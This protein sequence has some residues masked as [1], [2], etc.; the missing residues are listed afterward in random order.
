M[1]EQRLFWEKHRDESKE[2]HPIYTY[3]VGMT[4]SSHSDNGMIWKT[5]L[6]DL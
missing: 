5:L 3:R 2:K 6:V 1:I 4:Q